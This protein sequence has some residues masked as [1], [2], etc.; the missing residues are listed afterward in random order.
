MTEKCTSKAPIVLIGDTQSTQLQ[1][2]V[3][4][5]F[6]Q[7][8]THTHT[9]YLDKDVGK[10]GRWIANCYNQIKQNSSQDKLTRN[11]FVAYYLV[12]QIE[13]VDRIDVTKGKYLSLHQMYNCVE[14]STSC[15][16][17]Y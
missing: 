11:K 1:L 3:M 10:I 6:T 17:K 8:Y 15:T 4:F 16:I 13:V 12:Y 2:Y 14:V 7:L 5:L 9:L